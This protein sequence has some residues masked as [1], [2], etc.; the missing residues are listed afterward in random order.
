VVVASPPVP[1]GVAVA[2]PSELA[3][4]AVLRGVAV[5]TEVA[6]GGPVV[7][8]GATVASTVGVTVGVGVAGAAAVSKYQ[9]QAI[10]SFPARL[11]SI[12]SFATSNFVSGPLPS[13]QKTTADCPL[14]LSNANVN[15]PDTAVHEAAL[16][17]DVVRRRVTSP[18]V[19]ANAEFTASSVHVAENAA[20]SVEAGSTPPPHRHAVAL[21]VPA[22]STWP[23]LAANTLTRIMTISTR[24]LIKAGSQCRP[25]GSSEYD[26]FEAYSMSETLSSA[27]FHPGLRG[28]GDTTTMLVRIRPSR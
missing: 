21:T 8:V 19:S 26:W 25:S 18:A 1:P 12:E 10:P 24:R 5:A 14:R 17:A 11:P 3:G 4:V 20:G 28:D 16:P 9:R 6:V 15:G 7:C 27:E 2:S 23:T 22:A 13:L